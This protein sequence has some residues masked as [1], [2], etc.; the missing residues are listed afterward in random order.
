MTTRKD[1]ANQFGLPLNAVEQIDSK[2][3]FIVDCSSYPNSFD[4]YSRKYYSVSLLV[5]YRTI[6]GIYHTADSEWKL[7][8]KKYSITT[9][10]QLSDFSK[11]HNAWRVTEEEFNELLAVVGK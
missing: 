1:I 8:S 11:T 7:T 4:S 2:Q 10:R 5:S 3:L 9:T 6:V